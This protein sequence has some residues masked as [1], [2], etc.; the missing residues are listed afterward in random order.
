MDFDL[1]E[2]QQ[3]L[4]TMARD[5][6]LRECTRLHVRELENDSRGYD[7]DMLAKMA[8][9]GW[10]GLVLPEKYGGMG[11]GLLDLVVLL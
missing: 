4:R 8:E 1:N 5:F 9:L 2:Q 11:A 6:L 10:L 3:M 7:P